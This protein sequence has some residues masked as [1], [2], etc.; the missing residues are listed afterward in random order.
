[1]TDRKQ[2]DL[3]HAFNRFPEAFE[4]FSSFR[5]FFPMVSSYCFCSDS[6]GRET[7]NT[8]VELLLSEVYDSAF[9]GLRSGRSF[10]QTNIYRVLQRRMLGVRLALTGHFRC[11]SPCEEER[12]AAM[13]ALSVFVPSCES[14]GSFRSTQ[15]QQGAQCWCVDPTGR[16]VPGTRRLG[17]A[18]LCSE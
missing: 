9:S 6:R 1:M 14:G 17:D 2:L 5:K 11:P 18:A 4:T 15:C 13:E 7:E 8:G 10:S 16:E 3:L 12:R